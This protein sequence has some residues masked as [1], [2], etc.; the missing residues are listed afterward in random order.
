MPALH[1]L[2]PEDCER[3]L[4]RGTFGRVGL[5]TP[6]GPMI[7]PVNYAVSDDAVVIRTSAQGTLARYGHERQ[8]V[9]EVDLVEEERWR[10]WSVLAHGR[11]LLD[12]DPPPR[13]LGERARPW[14][15]GDRTAELRLVWTEL[16]G[17]RVGTGGD[18]AGPAHSR[19]R[20]D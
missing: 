17:R 13:P 3:L 8:L 14:A 18:P 9:F 1:D 2:D 10:G 6:T 4:R 19:H 7:L 5:W 15:E 16:T 11:G 20:V 12:P